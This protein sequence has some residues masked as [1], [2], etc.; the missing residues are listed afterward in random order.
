MLERNQVFGL[1]RHDLTNLLNWILAKQKVVNYFFTKLF[2][3]FLSLNFLCYWLG[4]ILI[5]P[6]YVFGYPFY[7][8]SKISLPVG[9]MGALFDSL[10]FYI[11][12]WIIR[13]A[14][15]TKSSLSYMTHL[16]LDFIIAILA[17]FWVLFVFVISGWLINQIEGKS[18]SQRE[19]GGMYVVKKNDETQSE[20]FQK[21]G[22]I[23]RT[24]V[25]EAMR[26]PA[27][28]WRNILFGVIMGLSA[29][30]PTSVHVMMFFKHLLRI[31]KTPV[32]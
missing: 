25:E 13:H 27:Q 29:M 10:S 8:Y 4:M 26:N 14:L 28:N 30:L 20:Q 24:R 5:F 18:Y 12:L 1:W 32:G 21:R 17:T 19:D 23:Y 31:K 2:I 9:F 3:F 6:S 16:F 7:H 15:A 22:E 11:T